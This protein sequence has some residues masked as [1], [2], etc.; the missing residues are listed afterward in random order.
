[1]KIFID[2]G[3]RRGTDALK[4]LALGADFAFIGRPFLFALAA[5]QGHAEAQHALGC[6]YMPDAGTGTGRSA[7]VGPP[8][9]ERSSCA[10]RGAARS[11][12]TPVPRRCKLTN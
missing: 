6:M 5:A 8:A 12:S 2:G 11:T 10:G 7:S 4:A 9:G 3:I 1:M